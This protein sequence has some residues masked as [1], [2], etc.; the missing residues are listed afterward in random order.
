MLDMPNGTEASG[1]MWFT[2]AFART[3]GGMTLSGPNACICVRDG[4]S[5][6][7][8]CEGSLVLGQ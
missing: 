7:R 6:C 2:F 1:G 3:C 8:A 4:S 5:L